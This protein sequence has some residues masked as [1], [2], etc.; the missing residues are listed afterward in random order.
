MKL[1][2]IAAATL[3]TAGVCGLATLADAA[4]ATD[5]MPVKAVHA[6]THNSWNGFYAG[7]NAGYGWDSSSIDH[8]ALTPFNYPAAIRNN[9]IPASNDMSSKGFMGG[10]QAGYNY[11]F[12]WALFGAETD[13]AYAGIRGSKVSTTPS[14]GGPGAVLITTTENKNLEWFGTAR[15][16]LGVLPTPSMLLY[17][18]GG[19]AYGKVSASTTTTVPETAFAGG[20]S[21]VFGGNFFCS[22]GSDNRWKAGWTIGAGLETMV[23]GNWS[24]RAEYLYYDLGNISYT[25]IATAPAFTGRAVMQ[26]DTRVDGHIIRIGLNYKLY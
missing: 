24:A 11:Q 5:F 8:S 4:D 6:A 19:L 14:G 25:S 10:I 21:G 22:A 9:G 23:N 7:V 17:L 1:R 2:W 12:G 16:R 26:S 13:I 18:A 20:C 3:A 15:G